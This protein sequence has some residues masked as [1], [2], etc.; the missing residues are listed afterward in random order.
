LPNRESETS[1]FRISDTIAEDI[2]T[3]GERYVAPSR[4]PILGRA[5]LYASTVIENGLQVDPQEPPEKHANIIGWPN[6]KSEQ[7][8]IAQ[9]L[10]AKAQL[11]TTNLHT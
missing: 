10:A 4:G 9:E 1:V 2:W 6:E 8:L 3:I 7:K 11:I 5:D